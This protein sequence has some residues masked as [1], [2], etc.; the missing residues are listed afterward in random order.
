MNEVAEPNKPT[1]VQ[2]DAGNVGVLDLSDSMGGNQAKGE[3][4]RSVA[5]LRLLVRERMKVYGAPLPD[6]YPLPPGVTLEDLLKPEPG[7]QSR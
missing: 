7:T 6:G 3:P 1:E 2:T 4:V 5:A